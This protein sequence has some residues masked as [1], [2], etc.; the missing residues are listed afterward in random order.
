[1]KCPKQ[2]TRRTLLIFVLIVTAGGF[3]PIYPKN[4]ITLKEVFDPRRISVNDERIFIAE[5]F[6]IHIYKRK[7]F[8]FVKTFGRRGEGPGEYRVILKLI[9]GPGYVGVSG[10]G[11]IHFFSANGDFIRRVKSPASSFKRLT[12]L[13]RKYVAENTVSENNRMYYTINLIE[14]DLKTS[15]ELYRYLGVFD[16]PGGFNPIEPDASFYISGNMIYIK[17]IDSRIHSFNE[18][19]KKIKVIKLD[20]SPVKVPEQFKKDVK[21]YLKS[22]KRLNFVYKMYKNNFD[23]PDHYPLIR[24]MRVADGKIYVI[25]YRSKNQKYECIAMSLEGNVLR[26]A[27]LPIHFKTIL[28]HYPFDI[29]DDILYQAVEDEDDEAIKLHVTEIK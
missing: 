3:H 7:D 14:A 8:T 4:A 26:R 22:H 6:S 25:T 21:N 11:T 9:S 20:T 17:G 23:F 29:K 13:G 15:S 24:F 5:R 10:F 28:N 2:F 16:S 18:H 19:G 27:Y 12:P 1:M